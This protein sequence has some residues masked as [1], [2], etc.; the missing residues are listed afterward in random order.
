MADDPHDKGAQGKGHPD[1]T[2]VRKALKQEGI[3][4]CAVVV[5]V[6]ALP[7]PN[8]CQAVGEVPLMHHDP[9]V[10][11][12]RLEEIDEGSRIPKEAGLAGAL[13]HWAQ[14]Y[15]VYQLQCVAGVVPNCVEVFQH[16]GNQWKGHFGQPFR[17]L[18]VLGCDSVYMSL[19]LLLSDRVY[20]AHNAS[21][22]ECKI[23]VSASKGELIHVVEQCCSQIARNWC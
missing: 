16:E 2:D 15:R 19:G 10:H 13:V 4:T 18:K 1:T 20:I 14:T 11:H 21:T 5:A 8:R 17:V 9:M 7:L 23:A 22:I 3:C 12:V 6:W